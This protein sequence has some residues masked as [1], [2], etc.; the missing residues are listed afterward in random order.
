M[1]KKG[2]EKLS[3]TVTLSPGKKTTIR[4]Q[5]TST[6][7]LLLVL[8]EPPGADLYL[9]G[10]HQG[11]VVSPLSLTNLDQG[12]HQAQLVLPG[13]RVATKEFEVLPHR[14]AILQLSLEKLNPVPQEW[15]PEV[16]LH[17][18]NGRTFACSLLFEDTE[19]LTVKVKAGK[20]ILNRDQIQSIESLDAD[21]SP[22]GESGDEKK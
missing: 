3:R 8:C 12:K 11:K 15:K 21:G 22:E 4:E 2:C 18:T 14:T 13:Y 20:L 19:S 1:Q 16:L 7:G 9:D 6:N 17:L 10:K 5:L